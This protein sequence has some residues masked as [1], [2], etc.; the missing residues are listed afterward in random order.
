MKHS[1]MFRTS[2]APFSFYFPYQMLNITNFYN[3]KEFTH[4]CNVANTVITKLFNKL[5]QIVLD[6]TLIINSEGCYMLLTSA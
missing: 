1:S 3:I 6:I 5:I 4:I 2:D